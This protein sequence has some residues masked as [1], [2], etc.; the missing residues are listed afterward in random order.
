MSNNNNSGINSVLL[1]QTLFILENYVEIMIIANNT[2]TQITRQQQTMVRKMNVLIT[3]LRRQQTIGSTSETIKEC[4]WF[5][6]RNKQY[7]YNNK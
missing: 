6:S 1:D 5:F 3:E 7:Q 4:G 2:H